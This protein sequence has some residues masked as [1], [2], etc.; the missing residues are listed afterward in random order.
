MGQSCTCVDCPGEADVF[1]STTFEFELDGAV[2]NDLADPDQSICQVIV[3]FV[4][5]HIWSL[6]MV[7]TS[8]AGQSVTIIGAPSP[9]FGFTGPLPWEI[10]FVPCAAV[11]DPDTG[12]S[13]T[14]DNN[15]NW[16]TSA[17]YN[18]SYHPYN[19][20]LEDFDLGAVNGTW[21][22]TVNNTSPVNTA[23]ILDFQVIPCDL[24]GLDCFDCTPDGGA[25]ES[26]PP[27]DLC[28][29]DAALDFDLPIRWP[30]TIPDSSL[31]GYTYLISEN[32]ILL[33]VD[34]LL[35][36]TDLSPGVYQ[37]CGLSYR[38]LDSLEI[39]VPDGVLTITEI[40]DDLNGLYNLFCAS[41]SESCAEINIIGHDT[42][43][44]NELLCEGQDYNF[45]DTTISTAGVY[46]NDVTSSIGCDSI[47]ELTINFN[48]IYDTIVFDTICRGD[49][50]LFGGDAL[51][52]EGVYFWDSLSVNGCDSSVELRLAIL[53]PATTFIDTIICRGE[54]ITIG[55]SS[56]ISSGYY[57]EVIPTNHLCDS[58]VQ[59]NLTV[60]NPEANI[61]VP[62]LL[63]C[64]NYPLTLS[65]VGASGPEVS[66]QWTDLDNGGLGLN[67]I[68]DQSTAEVILAGN[69]ELIVSFTQGNISC[70]DTTS[71]FVQAD[72]IPPAATLSAPTL[73]CQL[74]VAQITTTP[75]TPIID[76]DWTGPDGYTAADQNP[77]INDLGDYELIITGANGCE[78]TLAIT[79]H[80][81][82]LPPLIN[83]DPLD[84]ID[85]INNSVTLNTQLADPAHTLRWQGPGGFEST[86][87]N[88]EI[89]SPGTY[90]LTV[91][92][93]DNGCSA[94][95]IFNV[96]ENIVYPVY[97]IQ[98][99]PI[100]CNPNEGT[101]AVISI[102]S[103]QYSWEDNGGFISNDSVITV[104]NSG[105]FYLNITG[106]NGCEVYDTIF[107]PVDSLIPDILID[108]TTITCLDSFSIL[109]GS[110]TTSGVSYT[111]SD[112]SGFISNSPS[113]QVFS[114]QNYTL[115]VES[116]NG[117]QNELNFIPAIDTVTPTI[118]LP[119][120]HL[121]CNQ[122]NLQ[123]IPLAVSAFDVIFWEGPGG[124]FSILHHPVLTQTGD[125]TV[126]LTGE[127]GCTT[128]TPFE[129]TSDF[130]M[131]DIALVG[132]TLDCNNP[133]GQL[134][135]ISVA[136]D[137]IFWEGPGGFTSNNF[138]IQPFDTGLY[139][140]TAIG[141]NGCENQE[142]VSLLADFDTPQLTLSNSIIDCENSLAL[143]GDSTLNP[144]WNYIW[145]G[146]GGFFSTES[147]QFV[148]IPGNYQ[149]IVEGENGCQTNVPVVIDIDTTTL[150]ITLTDDTLDCNTSLINLTPQIVGTVDALEWI[151]PGGGTDNNLT[152]LISIPGIYQF[153]ASGANG[154]ESSAN[155]SIAIDTISPVVS[156][157]SAI[158]S[159]QNPNPILNI[160]VIANNPEF[161]WDGPAS[162]TSNIAEPNVTISGIYELLVTSSNGC[163]NSA[164][165]T[166]MDDLDLPVFNLQNDTLDCD[167][168]SIALNID[169]TG[170]YNLFWSGPLGFTSIQPSPEVNNPGIYQALV[171]DLDNGCQDSAVLEIFIDTLSPISTIPDYVLDCDNNQ[172]QLIPDFSDISWTYYWSGP[173]SFNSVLENPLVGIPGIYQLEITATNG[174][175]SELISTV[176]S[177]DSIP[178]L[179]FVFDSLSCNQLQA[180]INVSAD[181]IGTS[182][183]WTGPQSYTASGADIAVNNPGIYE[184]TGTALNGC[185]V[186]AD[187]EIIADTIAPIF[188]IADY[189]INC[190]Q[191][192]LY[193]LPEASETLEYTWWNPAS[194]QFQSDSLL[195]DGEGIYAVMGVGENGC[196]T[197]LD[198]LVTEDFATPLLSTN[199]LTLNCQ[200]SL[201]NL[202]GN[203]ISSIDSF[204]WTGPNSFFS[205]NLNPQINLP[206]DYQLTGIGTNGCLDSILAIVDI[207]TIAPNALT[208]AE[209]ITCQ[210]SLSTVAA[211]GID[212]GW[213]LNWSGPGAFFT[214]TATFETAIAGNYILTITGNNFCQTAI[215]QEVLIDQEVPQ[216]S[217][218]DS[219]ID[220]NQPIITLV[221]E[222]NATITNYSWT[223][224]AIELSIADEFQVSEAGIYFLNILSDNGCTGSTSFTIIA[225]Q[226]SPE[227][228]LQMDTIDCNIDSVALNITSSVFESINWSGPNSFSSN[229]LQPLIGV[230]GNYDFILTGANGCDTTGQINIFEDQQ[231]PTVQLNA[232]TLDCNI[233]SLEISAV[234]NFITAAWSGPAAF[235]SNE[236]MPMINTPGW[237]VGTFTGTNG[238]TIEDSILINE[239]VTIPQ[240]S[241]IGDSLDCVTT[242]VDL[243][244][245][246]S[247]VLDSVYWTGPNNYFSNT[248]ITAVTEPGWFIANAIGVNGCQGLDSILVNENID[249]PILEVIG[250]TLD[251]T[252]QDAMITASAN[253]LINTYFWIGPNGFNSN[254]PTAIITEAGIYDLEIV[255][256]N[257]CMDDYQVTVLPAAIPD[258][259]D[260]IGDNILNCDNASQQL[261]TSTQAIDFPFSI[262]WSL[263][264]TTLGQDTLLSVNTPGNY[265]LEVI[266]TENQCSSLSSMIV[267]LDT[268]SPIISVDPINGLN[269]TCDINE[270]LLQ[271]FVNGNPTSYNYYWISEGDTISTLD[272]IEINAPGE[273][274]FSVVNMDNGCLASQ[275][276]EVEQST[277]V[278]TINLEGDDLLNCYTP[279]TILSAFTNLSEN[280]A[281]D[282]SWNGT[283]IPLNDTT[284]SLLTDQ[285][286]IYLVN[287]VNLLNGCE[288]MDSFEVL[289]DFTQPNIAINQSNE[290]NCIDNQAVLTFI[291]STGALVDYQWV[292]NNDTL[293]TNIALVV[294]EPGIITLQATLIENGCSGSANIN[295]EVGNLGPQELSLEI[296]Q[297]ICP[298]DLGALSAI[299][300][301]GGVG[302]YL[303]SFDEGPFST[304]ALFS[305]LQPN[306]Y[307]LL[308][309]DADGCE[310]S[311]LILINPA[312]P[313]ALELGED[314]TIQLGDSIMLD[315][316]YLG[317]I[318]DFNWSDPIECMNCERPFVTPVKT[319]EYF[320]TVIDDRGCLAEDR[321]TIFVEEGES[322]YF[323]NAFSPDNNGNNDVYQPFFSAA[324]SRVNSFSIYS[325]WGEKVF[326]REN[327]DPHLDPIIWDG[328]FRGQRVNPGVFVYHAEVLLINGKKI[329]FSGDLTVVH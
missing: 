125:H 134:T 57:E 15:Q 124:Y 135:A 74:S 130:S 167:T 287:I 85:C 77:I 115:T 325:R 31:Y 239:D 279:E 183:E 5:E 300:V 216:L 49:Q 328:V 309:Q 1:T 299:D 128:I 321:I 231:L 39:P 277:E 317:T 60:L 103:N 71:A 144:N 184:V 69:Y 327:V 10:Q 230:P 207:D 284:S 209:I 305:Q 236:F 238:C 307:S 117:C 109:S 190:Y 58:T 308:V 206:G 108:G 79:V 225:D 205:S 21:T 63:D 194:Q 193:A 143:L 139:T 142:N 274:I 175:T 84:T 283:A 294:N 280:Y 111:W 145:T 315:P 94:D 189:S 133:I 256:N 219:L 202:S 118:T 242:Q 3:Q 7:L 177:N 113:I 17:I 197:Q 32:D 163:L 240:F 312:I 37:I 204:Y 12:F 276:L 235:I 223:D 247:D 83:L 19:G 110:S 34:S 8:P 180:N 86:N 61:D 70:S 147:F 106:A 157:D 210:D 6:Q 196:D 150:Q 232:G 11:P 59:L 159:C 90:E 297:P 178:V 137:S 88:I 42:T 174:C 313:I 249:L 310:I 187:V 126:F 255:G 35:V 56:F 105:P 53:I 173:G 229:E 251:C 264:N 191:P 33:E 278:P 192:S 306:N 188:T 227:Y 155:A 102:D 199:N 45:I 29:G 51:E 228:T 41:L 182:F 96:Y 261:M 292:Q 215:E 97:G 99:T 68:N 203:L 164:T 81:D 324:V 246:S 4:P 212:P 52:D 43:Y 285:P 89:F 67:S 214:N 154:C 179:E 13:P 2:N 93:P 162:F 64:N 213:L 161:L 226:Q 80:G 250:D 62:G 211:T 293:D 270:I 181:L 320:L 73:D 217:V 66:Y 165:T 252:G 146:P 121:D 298:G 22:L 27:Q 122:Q 248:L 318:N 265:M 316:V 132:D 303:Y 20:C 152:Q 116:G 98:T 259:L 25:F 123:V 301:T 221:P 50:Y 269:I 141:T 169:Y 245:M 171:T 241:L 54:S 267:D 78:D 138:T 129:V 101:I 36:L 151:L 262:N 319:T 156:I 257:G 26:E 295:I 260:I 200:D 18:G 114:V 253:Q 176:T 47:I 271:G 48:P 168:L 258:P 286:G 9:Q 91:F 322:G 326:A 55:S 92:N 237:Y 268:I 120:I 148:N 28:A 302:P 38:L 136:A 186:F 329:K 72:L 185:E 87:N 172:V 323:P 44:I 30:D 296:E 234:G 24:E 160:N 220:C 65:A 288:S 149:A 131:P 224:G 311:D 275:V 23:T 112:S 273:F 289:D 195:I 75:L 233:D 201:L 40:S 46:L 218:A 254:N 82:T 281:Y 158:I 208:Q 107:A 263:N 291:E 95:T 272:N 244:L 16:L 76:Y 243:Q 290:L 14:W 266:N 100:Q 198:F 119:E 166:V 222:T 314:Q 127:N 282:W 140:A 170:N 304:E 153:T 104:N